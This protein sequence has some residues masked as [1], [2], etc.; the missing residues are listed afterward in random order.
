MNV[1]IGIKVGNNIETDSTPTETPLDAYLTP[2]G[3]DYYRTPDD[4][5]YYQQ[6]S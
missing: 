6:P 5:D 4:T 2:S 3:T 1:S